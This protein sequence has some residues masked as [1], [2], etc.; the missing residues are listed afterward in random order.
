MATPNTRIVQQDGRNYELI[1][2]A[3]TMS[4]DVMSLGITDCQRRLDNADCRKLA[5]YWQFGRGYWLVAP[6]ALP[7]GSV[8]WGVGIPETLGTAVLTLSEAISNAAQFWAALDA[9]DEAQVAAIAEVFAE[10][11]LLP[12]GR[13]PAVR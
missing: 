3:A 11:E 12:A 6:Q 5:I 8:R 2:D 4:G 10:V 7:F 9:R 1:Y 13:D